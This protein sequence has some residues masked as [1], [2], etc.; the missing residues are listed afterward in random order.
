MIVKLKKKDKKLIEDIDS[1]F[2]GL[3]INYDNMLINDT[4]KVKKHSEY[5]K[6]KCEKPCN[7]E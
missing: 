7:N 3:V 4:I 1:F 6:P 5:K 2:K